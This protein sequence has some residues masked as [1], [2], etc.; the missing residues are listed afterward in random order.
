VDRL[1]EYRKLSA[2]AEPLVRGDWAFVMHWE[3]S[4]SFG[5]VLAFGDVV[6]GLAAMVGTDVPGQ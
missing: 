5:Y 3:N 6:S 4:W 1:T 2:R